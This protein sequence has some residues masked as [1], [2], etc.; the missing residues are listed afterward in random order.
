[1]DYFSKAL[2]SLHSTGQKRVFLAAWYK[3]WSWVFG[4]L[5]P[6]PYSY[7]QIWKFIS[8]ANIIRRKERKY[9]VKDMEKGADSPTDVF[10]QQIIFICSKQTSGSHW[11]SFQFLETNSLFNFNHSYTKCPLKLPC[12]GAENE[13]VL[14]MRVYEHT[15]FPYDS[16]I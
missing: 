7:W 14:Q 16:L 15:T 11:Q 4:R 1:M 6:T 12:E 5:S 8:N 10:F 13:R 3:I 2:F 9:N